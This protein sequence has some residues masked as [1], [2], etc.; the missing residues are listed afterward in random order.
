MRYLQVIRVRVRNWTRSAVVVP[1][2]LAALGGAA[3]VIAT[4]LPML[5][6]NGTPASGFMP[7]LLAGFLTVLGLAAAV[8]A[9]AR[10]PDPPDRAPGL[11]S[12]DIPQRQEVRAGLALCL[13]VGLFAA[14]APAAGLLP[15]AGV[16]AV[17]CLVATEEARPATVALGA[18]TLMV[19]T[20]LLFRGLL[21]SA[22]PLFGAR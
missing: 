7:A 13:A 12:R 22:V 9:L 2:V 6:R 16:A 15:A 18:L 21:G 5:A 3:G 19:I 8:A 14:L 4:S 11:G 10:R 1:L 17:V 20:A